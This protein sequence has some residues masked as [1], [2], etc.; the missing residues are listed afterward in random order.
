MKVEF[1]RPGAFTYI[2]VNSIFPLLSLAS[3]KGSL[4]SLEARCSQESINTARTPCHEETTSAYDVKG[5]ESPGLFAY[6]QAN[7]GPIKSS[8]FN[9]KN[10][11]RNC[12][13]VLCL[14]QMCYVL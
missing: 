7:N 4:I 13:G 6:K 1:K 14:L 11:S 12:I 2:S 9:G 8:E 10:Q 3:K 5:L